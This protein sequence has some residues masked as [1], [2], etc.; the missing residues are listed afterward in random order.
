MFTSSRSH[1]FLRSSFCISQ[2]IQTLFS[3]NRTKLEYY[4]VSKQT[5]IESNPFRFSTGNTGYD[6]AGKHATWYHLVL[7]KPLG[8]RAEAPRRRAPLA[9]FSLQPLHVERPDFAYSTET[10][11]FSDTTFTF[12]GLA[13]SDGLAAA[14]LPLL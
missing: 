13:S 2:Q 1:N 10:L 14:S 8:S 5:L 7:S 12:F 9:M 11:A 6:E 3:I 4:N